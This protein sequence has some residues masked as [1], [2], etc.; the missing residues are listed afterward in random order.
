MLAGMRL[1]FSVRKKIS[2]SIYYTH[3]MS[4]N[5]SKSHTGDACLAVSRFLYEKKFT[6]ISRL[7]FT[8][9]LRKGSLGLSAPVRNKLQ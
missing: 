7:L 9:K 6:P 8:G 4:H 2:L 5:F 1:P 3:F